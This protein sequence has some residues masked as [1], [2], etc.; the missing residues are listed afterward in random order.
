[1]LAIVFASI[2]FLPVA[3][4]QHAC[5]ALLACACVQVTTIAD[6]QYVAV[7]CTDMSVIVRLMY[8]CSNGWH[9]GFICLL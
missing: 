7:R 6:D 9:V 4:A 3:K 1:M 2:V 8:A 5:L